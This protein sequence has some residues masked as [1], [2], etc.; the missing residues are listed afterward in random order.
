[1]AASPNH[2]KIV[3]MQACNVLERT[4]EN[5]VVYYFAN[6]TSLIALFT[7]VPCLKTMPNGGVVDKDQLKVT[8]VPGEKDATVTLEPKKESKQTPVFESMTITPGDVKEVKFTPTDKNGKPTG[9]TQTAPVPDSSKPTDVKFQKP[10]EADK[11]TVT[12]V[13]KSGKPSDADVISVRG[14]MPTE[15]LNEHFY[16]HFATTTIFEKCVTVFNA[17]QVYSS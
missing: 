10:I 2:G 8:K 11:L 3:G 7:D 12:F 4:S 6:Y 9:K 16:E 5:D 14:C 13:S 17:S 1:V 15:G